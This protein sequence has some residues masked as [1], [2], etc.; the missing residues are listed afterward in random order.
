MGLYDCFSQDIM[1]VLRYQENK[2]N[3]AWNDGIYQLIIKNKQ[4]I[5]SK[6]LSD[7]NGVFII[8]GSNVNRNKTYDVTLS[9]IGMIDN[10]LLTI[11]KNRKDTIIISLPK[12]YTLKSGYAI[13]PKCHR[14]DKVC[15]I[16]SEPILI[17]KLVKGK[18][19][20]SPI[21]KR[22]YYY[23]TDVWHTF[24]PLWYCK[25]DSIFF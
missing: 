22:T 21:G 13:C 2:N 14:S 10:F 12:K 24:N 8:P 1:L 7:T 20:Y 3:T 15:K 4:T 9:N 18:T 16:S 17:R 19:V 6:I 5:I 25:R 11:D 23:G